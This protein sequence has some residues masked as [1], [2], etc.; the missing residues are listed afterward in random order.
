M[1]ERR[2][3]SFTTGGE[4]LRYS[5]TLPR[6]AS[7]GSMLYLHGGGSGNR[8]R[9]DDL[10]RALAA[11]GIATFAFDFSGHG[12]SSGLMSRS[13]LRLRLEQ[14]CAAVETMGGSGPDIVMGNSMGGYVAAEL[15]ACLQ[16]RLLVLSCPA[17]YVAEAFDVPFDQRFTAILRQSRTF[18]GA[19]P[20]PLLRAFRGNALLVTAGQDR[21]IPRPVIDTYRRALRQTTLDLLDFPDA[22]HQI[23]DWIAQDSTRIA[24]LAARIAGASSLQVAQLNPSPARTASCPWW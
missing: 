20:L 1:I 19:R 4:T 23:H 21:V 10:A 9:I 18:D 24:L 22:P 7:A 16:P 8:R 17:L 6:D 5:W 13:S 2:D 12:D 15:L 3:G 14:A 11:R